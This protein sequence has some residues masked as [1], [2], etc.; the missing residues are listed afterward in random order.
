[1]RKEILDIIYD[2]DKIL[3]SFEEKYK[4][5]FDYL[6]EYQNEKYAQEYK[7]LVDYAK[8]C[9]QKIANGKSFSKAVATNYFKLMSYKD[10]YEVARLYSNNEFVK[11][12]KQSFEGNFKIN[13]YLAPPI[14]S[15]K[16]KVTGNS[17]KTKYGPWVMTLFKI[18]SKF[19][20]LRGTSFDP[21]GY[22]S[23]R[24]N[25]RKLIKD[26]KNCILDIGTKLSKNNY[27]IAV[28]IASVPDQIRGFGHV[29]EKNIKVAE[30]CQNNL[31]MTFN[32]SK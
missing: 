31:I 27:D 18:I 9:E 21:F 6:I 7:K 23:E 26:Y 32:E 17:L 5:R 1:M 10:E 14:F 20:F 28:D 24:K 29:K 2:K 22:L 25:E 11:K 3:T 4:D 8:S 30:D 19:K 12:I 16:D 13:F 15:T